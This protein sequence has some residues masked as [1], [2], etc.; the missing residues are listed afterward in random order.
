[1]KLSVELLKKQP[2]DRTFSDTDVQK[3]LDLI[4]KSITRISHQVDDVLG[5]VRNSPLRLANISVHELLKNFYR[6]N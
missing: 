2:S 3:R 6:K 5:Y 4:D 1:M